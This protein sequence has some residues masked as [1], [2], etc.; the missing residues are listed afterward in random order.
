MGLSTEEVTELYRQHADVVFRRC[1]TML[2]NQEDAMDAVQEIYLKVLTHREKFRGDADPTTWI[3]RITT[4]HALNL[5]RSRRAQTT[6]DSLPLSLHPNT[7]G[8]ENQVL[9]RYILFTILKHLDHRSQAILFLHF[10]EGLHQE[11]V[12]NVLGISRRAVVKRLTRIR[13]DLESILKNKS[14]EEQRGDK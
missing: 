4:N 12:A 14:L 7:C 5:I 10:V 11:E 3:Y 1:L 13:T 9:N 2:G 6:L 8:L